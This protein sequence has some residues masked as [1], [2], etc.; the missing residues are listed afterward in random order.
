M[1]SHEQR[2]DSSIIP[3]LS[4]ELEQQL[5]DR[6]GSMSKDGVVT[7]WDPETATACYV[8]VRVEPGKPPIMARWTLEGPVSRERAVMTGRQIEQAASADIDATSPV[9]IN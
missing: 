5:A 1:T 9:T 4:V 2:T 7:V 6:I 8:L 3:L